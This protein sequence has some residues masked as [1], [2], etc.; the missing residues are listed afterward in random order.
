[1]TLEDIVEDFLERQRRGEAPGV[2]E[3]ADRFP[4]L[5]DEIR[6]TLPA[7]AALLRFA[8]EDE[9]VP[10]ELSAVTGEAGSTLPEQ[11][12]DYRILGKIGRGG[13]GVV[14]EAEQVSLGRRVALKVLPRRGLRDDRSLARFRREARAAARLHHTNIVPVFEVGEDGDNAFY[15]MQLIQGRGLDAVIDDL[16]RLR[17]D[18]G[19]GAKA[20]GSSPRGLVRSLVTGR[21]RAENLVESPA[22]AGPPGGSTSSPPRSASPSAG[23]VALADGSDGGSN[24]RQ[25]YRSVATLGLQA[26]DAL[27]YAHARGVLHRD[28]KPSN[29]LLDAAGVVWLT[30]FGLA[31][32]EDDGLTRPGDVLGTVR[33]MA[34][35]RFAGE[36]GARADVYSLGLTLYELLAL[37]PAFDGA[38]RLA[39][40]E[41]IRHAD[42][43][44][45]RAR[46]RHVPRD[47][48]TVVLKAIDKSPRGRYQSAEELAA[49][50]R[51]FLDGEPV[52]A[53]RIT[54]LERAAKWV[55]RR[56]TAAA[57][58]LLSPLVVLLA[59]AGAVTT[60]MWLQA[61]EAHRDAV[62]QY[63]TARAAETEADRQRLRAEHALYANRVMR[64][65]FEWLG[66]GAARADQL[67]RQCPEG[68]RDWEWHYVH[69]LCHSDLSTFAGADQ[70]LTCIASAP[71]GE[72]FAAGGRD[73]GVFVW[74]PDADPP[75]WIPA[76]HTGDVRS[77]CF[78]PDGGRVVSAGTDRTAKVWDART[79]ALRHTLAGHAG[80]VR[81]VCV[82]PDGT[83]IAT[84]S[85]DGTVKL[86]DAR[87]SEV[88]TL[89]GR[90]PRVMAV[91]FRPDGRRVAALGLAGTLQ[92][93]DA[94]TR[95]AI[96]SDPL[97]IHDPIS[98]CYSP[99]GKRIA[100]ASHNGRAVKVCDAETLSEVR[101]LT[102]PSPAYIW[103]LCYHPDGGRIALATSDRT[104]QVWDTRT[105]AR[106]RAIQGHTDQVTGV[107]Y[108]RDGE[109]LASASWDQ[110][111]RVWDPGR[112]QHALHI[113]EDEA[114]VVGV[115]YSPD[116]ERIASASAGRVVCSDPRT[117]QQL[118]VFEVRAKHGI[119]C[120]GPDGGRLATGG[121]GDVVQIWDVGTGRTVQTL[122]GHEQRPL[123]VSFSP[124][125]DRLVS[126][127]EDGTVRMWNVRSGQPI[128]LWHVGQPI[129]CVCFSPDGRRIVVGGGRYP[130]PAVL[131][132]LDAESGEELMN[133]EGH[134][135]RV[136]GVCFSPD[137]SRIATAGAD[138]TVRLWD[139][140]SGRSILGPLRGHRSFVSSVCFSLDGKRLVSGG[141]DQTIRVWDAGSG[142]EVLVL[143][144]EEQVNSVCF[145]P[146]GRQLASGGGRDRGKGL[147]KLWAAP[148]YAPRGEPVEPPPADD[149]RRPRA[150][151]ALRPGADG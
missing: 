37:T 45:P 95:E 27:A 137:G 141:W 113:A 12:G 55:R 99:D 62:V 89:V 134:E 11:I 121:A 116:G 97:R 32:T 41:Q 54:P 147:V 111:V 34:P 93:W 20:G 67:L 25:Y 136:Y 110:T 100:C 2:A 135:A 117:G 87:G 60:A 142:Q 138:Q 13:M 71:D 53:R 86:W 143:K 149:P 1:M 75:L 26:A 85:L 148:G 122:S 48:E 14:Y 69:R 29:L 5:A 64:A 88:G 126:G 144:N 66:N 101:T 132:V 59:A 10:S 151:D 39:L 61:D 47:L 50:L 77:V 103:D 52:R 30:D 16:R 76:G 80:P 35:E 145:S 56:P 92:V 114:K 106:L 91:C 115:C 139:A 19:E 82:S 33:Y 17:A 9:E 36:G 15:T 22:P 73:G 28:V 72:R 78:S 46:D 120:F 112:D 140:R 107:C 7:L 90:D 63:A 104:V 131:K 21:F 42:P 96:C 44:P 129:Q 105:G 79:G 146:D 83:R 130:S 102:L 133:L 109:R 65:H 57:V 38:D 150:A 43:V 51:R 58:C 18:P 127:A 119:V 94:R 70:Q 123:A 98:L 49:D 128:R 68:L 8:P 24:L 118:S 23:P 4:H 81:D 74:G 84:A 40:I 108:T 3:Y 124:D 125:G 6:A 31:K